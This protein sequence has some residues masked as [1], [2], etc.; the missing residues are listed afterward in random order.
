MR[1]N[2]KW[3]QE[4]MVDW[5]TFTDNLIDMSKEDVLFAL[6]L[7]NEREKPRLTVLKRLKQRYNAIAAEEVRREIE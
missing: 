3:V 1:V 6:E 7:E 5:I 2:K 4:I